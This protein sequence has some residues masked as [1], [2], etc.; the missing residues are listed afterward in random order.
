MQAFFISLAAVFIAELGDKT[1]LVTLALATR[2]KAS[3][4]LAGVFVS[5]LTL[6]LLSVAIGSV[7][8]SLLP[9][10]WIKYFAGMAFIAFGLWTIRGEHSQKEDNTKKSR[11]SSPFLIVAVTFFIAELGDK[12]MLSMVTLG[13][14]YSPFPVWL[15]SSLGLI[16]SD[17]LAILVGSIMGKNLPERPI[18][19]IAACFFFAFG[20]ISIAQVAA[21]LPPIAWAAGIFG[22]LIS[23][24]LIFGGL[25]SVLKKL[26]KT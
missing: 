8:G 13:A 16:I 26:K 1:Q 11:F 4:V 7:F 21:K 5:V 18:K 23:A 14:T 22:L 12:T 19:I 6:S 24:L 3:V 9:T 17:T 20:A 15:G 2:Y 10:T 25:K